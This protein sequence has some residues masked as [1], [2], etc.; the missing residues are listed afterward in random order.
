MLVKQRFSVALA[1]IFFINIPTQAREQDPDAPAIDRP[2]HISD[3]GQYVDPY[4]P[5]YRTTRDGRLSYNVKSNQSTLRLYL[6]APEKITQNYHDSPNGPAI[7]ATTTSFN[8]NTT[9]LR[10]TNFGGGNVHTGICEVPDAQGL[11]LIHI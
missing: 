5:V 8:V 3:R 4:I 9:R 6:N 11:S 1:L 2:V 10:A 7:L